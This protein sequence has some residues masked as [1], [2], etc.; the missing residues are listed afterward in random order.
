MNRML[1]NRRRRTFC[2]DSVTY[3]EQEISCRATK[4]S[5]YRSHVESWDMSMFVYEGAATAPSILYSDMFQV[6]LTGMDHE[7]K[8]AVYSENAPPAGGRAG[9]LAQAISTEM[10]S[11]HLSLTERTHD[12]AVTVSH[13]CMAYVGIERRINSITRVASTNT[14]CCRSNLEPTSADLNMHKTK[15][16]ENVDD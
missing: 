1:G 13:S 15:Q 7:A 12:P 8:A 4:L 2:L 3:K 10:V 14:C 9:P 5:I 11:R 16:K 6:L